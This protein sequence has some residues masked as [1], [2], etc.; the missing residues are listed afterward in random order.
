M[1]SW[2]PSE[3]QSGP[4]VVAQAREAGLKWEMLQTASWRRMSRGQYSWSGL[5]D[6]I[7]LKLRAV[8]ARLPECAAFS[9][10]TAA[11][12]HGLDFPPEPIEV[13]VPRDISVRSR[14]GVKLRRASLDRT[15]RTSR[16]GFRVTTALRTVCDLGSR[17]DVVESTVA[18]DMALK[19]GL[20]KLEE[21]ARYV[22]DNAGAKGVRRLRRAV[23]LAEP[24]CESPMETRLRLELIRARLPRP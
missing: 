1:R 10:R 3:L 9:G 13:T 22:E 2:I 21:L 19:G 6:D 24:R 5:S 11:W 17:A 7:E 23:G 15:D 20:V 12:L 18:V 8:Q 14:A 4:F 16:R